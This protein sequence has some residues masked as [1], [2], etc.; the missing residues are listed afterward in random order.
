MFLRVGFLYFDSW[1]LRVGFLDFDSW[2][3]SCFSQIAISSHGT[4]HLALS[5][6]GMH[7][8][9]ASTWVTKF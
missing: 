9:T 6:V 8:T 3:F 2:F 1:F 4:L 5:L 7:S